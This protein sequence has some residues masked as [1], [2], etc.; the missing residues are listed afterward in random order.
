MIDDLSPLNKEQFSDAVNELER[1]L[2]QSNRAFLL[3]AGCSSCAGLPLMSQLTQEVCGHSELTD[4]TRRL[5]SSLIQQFQGST[6][7]TIEAYMSELV[8]MLSIA[9]RRSDCEASDCSL[10]LNGVE[11][12]AANLRDALSEIKILIADCIE[13]RSISLSTHQQF[14]QAIHNTLQSGKL[15]GPSAVDYFTLNYDTLFEDTLALE[16]IPYSDGF[17]GG[18][19]GWWDQNSFDDKKVAARVFKVHGSI[20]WCQLEDGIILRRVRPNIISGDSIRKAMIWPAATKYQEAQRDPYA[21][22]IY[23]MRQTLRPEEN[24]DTIFTICGYSFGDA[25][26]NIE[27]DRAL[28]DSEKRLTIIAFTS[29][30][31][32]EGLLKKWIAD[33]DVCD[34]V[35]IYARGGFYHGNNNEKS[36]EDL[37]WW[38]FETITRLLQGER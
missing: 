28:R 32:P 35:R 22:I 19:T 29:S 13:N 38:K 33:E 12:S 23:R 5:L 2:S 24:C 25:H 3:G 34:Q 17:L 18:T 7:V 11:Y 1:L 27:L 37:P 6:T 36:N 21:Q 26:I 20:D 8:D 31:E 4:A 15:I 9:E 30:L 16:R 10:K 14:I